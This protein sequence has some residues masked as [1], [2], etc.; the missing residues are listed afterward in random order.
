MKKVILL[1]IALTSNF[2]SFA[3]A[4]AAAYQTVNSKVA[5]LRISLQATY[6]ELSPAPPACEGGHNYGAHLVLYK[7][8][9]NFDELYSVLLTL[10]STNEEIL[11]I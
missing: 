6:I 2:S 10:Y 8:R 11:G 5:S 3:P 1:I 9:P 4:E 7:S